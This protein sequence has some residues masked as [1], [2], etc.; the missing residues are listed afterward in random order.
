MLQVLYQY[1]NTGYMSKACK[2]TKEYIFIGKPKCTCN[3]FGRIILLSR[4]KVPQETN[5]R[6]FRECGDEHHQRYV[7]L[8]APQNAW[9][10]KSPPRQM[11]S[12]PGGLG[13]LQTLPVHSHKARG[14]FSRF[15]DKCE[16]RARLYN[17][18]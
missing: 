3:T 1:T 4:A 11:P 5:R 2:E 15:A 12:W 7:P 6:T 16:A 8:Q 10:E 14:V 17:Q 9:Q 18:R 13:G